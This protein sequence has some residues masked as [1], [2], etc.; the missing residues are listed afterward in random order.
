MLLSRA[1]R[2][3]SLRAL[4]RASSSAPYTQRY[5]VKTFNAIS[6]VGLQQFPT[7]LY[8][9]SPDEEEPFAIMLRSHQLQDDEVP[10]SVRAIARC[11][12][13]T[14][15]VPVNRMTERGIPVFNSPGA[16]ANAVKELALCSLLMAS[17]GIVQS[18]GEIEKML[19]VE[20]DAG[21]IKKR[22]EAEKKKFGGCEIKGKT[23]GVI[24]L[25]YIGASVAEAALKL[26]MDVV[27]YDPA[28]SLEAAWRLPGATINRV[29]R[30]EELL[31][32]ADYITLHVPYIPEVTHHMLDLPALQCM[33][34]TCNI[35]N[36]ARGELI[37]VD[38]L[39]S[40]YKNG[41]FYGNYV[42]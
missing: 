3:G 1:A 12:A 14:N 29:M 41:T 30:L 11:G 39:A 25:G 10:S 2:P 18:I 37:D 16:N 15:N 7:A 6:P 27:A 28:I 8:D 32:K 21:V 24:G 36:F 42:S 23:L 26:G 19:A 31:S 33:K 34:P 20:T 4:V 9:V 38:A 5:R 35:I 17:R 13:G 40:M 22:V